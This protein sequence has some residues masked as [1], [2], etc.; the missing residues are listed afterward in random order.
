MAALPGDHRGLHQSQWIRTDGAGTGH[1]GGICQSVGIRFK[2]VG[3]LV[4][5]V[6]VGFPKMVPSHLVSWIRFLAIFAHIMMLCT[7]HDVW[8][9]RGTVA[10]SRFPTLFQAFQRSSEYQLLN[11]QRKSC[12]VRREL[13][14]QWGKW[15]GPSSV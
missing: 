9:H 15:T 13:N 6:P 14:C 4:K 3:P 8:W 1:G 10:P 5:I 2:I 7:Y 12:T 11:G